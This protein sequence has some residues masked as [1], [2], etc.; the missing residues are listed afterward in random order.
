MTCTA[1][2]ITEFSIPEAKAK[3]LGFAGRLFAAL[4]RDPAEKL[5]LEGLSDHRLRDLGLADGRAAAP[6]DRLRD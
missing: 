3:P 1:H 2:A 6:R 4:R 5:E